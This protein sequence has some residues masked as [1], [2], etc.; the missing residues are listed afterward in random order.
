[1]TLKKSP[2]LLAL[3]I[4][5]SLQACKSEPTQLGLNTQPSPQASS[6]AQPTPTQEV[7]VAAPAEFKA[8]FVG[9]MDGRFNIQMA[10]ER[11]GDKGAGGYFYDRA[12]AFNVAEKTLS[13]SGRI[14]KDGNATLTE[15]TQNFETGGEQKTGEF[16][17]K[18]DGVSLDGETSLK[19]S[20][21]WTSAKDGKQL[22]FDLR[23][24]RHDLGG[25]KLEEKKQK[26][27][28]RKLRLEVET[29]APQLAGEDATRTGKFNQ[30]VAAF[31]AQRTGEFKKEVDE[32]ARE[33]AALAA[34]SGKEQAPPPPTQGNSMDVGYE[35]LAANKDFISALFYF[36]EYTG[37]AHPNTTTAS[38]TYDLNRNAVVNLSD[39]FLPKSNYLKVISDY[40]IRELKK[41]KTVSDAETGA[42]AKLENFHSWN[43]TPTGLKITFDRYQVGAY[44]VGEHE[45]VVPYSVLKPIIR[46]DGLLAQFVK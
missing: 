32:M 34:K 45:V 17:G 37:G 14:D 31:V 22:P 24:L 15:T 26:S 41:V 13:L 35:V 5:I 1:M 20:G 40:A 38:F 10:I 4:A 33:D 23:E 25:L 42:A 29:N 16:K 3:A 43:I 11:K 36:S 44:A 7:V 27:G 12:G 6:Q 9:A 18:L 2:C 46:P 28:D 8:T 21:V 39:L 30:A 19:F